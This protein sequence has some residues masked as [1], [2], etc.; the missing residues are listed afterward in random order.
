MYLN[1]NGTTSRRAVTGREPTADPRLSAEPGAVFC[2][3]D[4]GA[5]RK[6]RDLFLGEEPLVAAASFDDPLNPQTLAIELSDGVGDASSARFDVRWS[7][8]DNYAFHYTDNC[9]R[10][11]RFDRHRKP[12][13]PTRHYHLPPDAPSRPVEPSCI[14]VLELPL[15]ARAVM[16][17]WRD[18]LRRGALDH[19]NEA[20]NPP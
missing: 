20:A 17:R 6:V 15:V 2:S 5:L 8:T 13:S 9:G 11:F 10:D 1:E 16:K 18:A 14:G 7:V 3:T 19:V 12:G 4:V